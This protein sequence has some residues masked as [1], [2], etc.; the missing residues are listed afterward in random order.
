MSI[1]VGIGSWADVEYSGVLYPK[2]VKAVQRLPWYAT[3]FNHV[4]VNSS[5]YRTPTRA[6][7]ASWVKATPPGSTFTVKL[8]RAFS[9]SPAKTADGDLPKRLLA[10]VA[11]LVRASRLAAFLP[12]L[13]PSFEPNRLAL[14]ER[15]GLAERL[16]PHLL[17]VELRDRRW[18][19]G[20]V[21][22]RT[23]DY[24]RE[25]GFVFVGV[26]L[27][28]IEDSTMLPPLDAVTNP[29]LAYLRLHGRNSSWLAAKSAAERHDY[30]YAARE[31]QEIARRV[32]RLAGKADEVHVIANNHAH[33]FA[34][35]T[36]LALQ[37][38]LRVSILP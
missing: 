13:P 4:E 9:Q 29:R 3:Q 19:T 26:D 21:R 16:R 15:D 17:A 34:P 1:R 11:P 12:V 22:V 25:R 14:T 36:A 37:R 24:F 23:F 8:H 2:A 7:T 5:Y 33:D 28:R 30:A 35:R 32:R 38:L 10:G 31:L 6:L 20:R 18:V 27:P